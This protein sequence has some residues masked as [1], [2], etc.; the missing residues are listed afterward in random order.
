MRA[1]NWCSAASPARSS[2]PHAPASATT[3]SLTVRTCLHACASSGPSEVLEVYFRQCSFNVT[4][5]D[6]ARMAATLARGGV[7][8]MTGRR[9]TDSVVVQR[10]LAVMV[11]CGMYDAAGDGVSAVGM[12]AKSG[13]GGG[14][15]A[16]LPGQLG[17]G[18]YSPL[19][20]DNGNSVRGVRVCRS[21]S[22]RLGLHFL[23]VTRESRSTIRTISDAY[24]RVRVYELHGDLLFAGTEQ[25]LRTVEREKDDFD[26]AILDVTRVDTINDAA[27]GLLAGMRAT[28]SSVGK[29]GFLVDPDN[30]VVRA[31]NQD[32]FDA[33]VF[34]ALDDA[35][36]AAR[37]AP[38]SAR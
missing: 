7:N 28:L 29:E 2:Q 27:R 36:A 30:A 20:D 3:L 23:T 38:V 11:T 37:T 6:L 9:V 15:V 13:V 4:S 18:I 1:A 21:L 31:E 19:L 14:I 26:V 34:G 25:V 12:P 8:P 24:D 35:V 5:T 17:I 33:L 22:Q 32:D 16:V 10:T